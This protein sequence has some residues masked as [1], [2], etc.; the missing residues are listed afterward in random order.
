[1]FIEIF[2]ENINPPLNLLIFGAG[3]D[4]LPVLKF[5]K[6]L[7]WQTTV[8]DHRPAFTDAERLSDAD[9]IIVSNSEDL[10]ERIFQDENSVGVIMTHNYERDRNILRLFVKFKMPIC[11]R[12]RTEKTHRKTSGR[13]SA[14][15][16]ALSNSKNFTRQS[17]STSVRIRRKRLHSPSSRKFR[18]F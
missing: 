12:T 14:K 6:E 8:I 1:M 15:I 5:A 7:G 18:A 10:S 4:A 13:K 16:S 2:F 17:D 3:Y 11:R 9:K